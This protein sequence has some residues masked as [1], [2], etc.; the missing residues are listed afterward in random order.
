MI[1]AEHAHTNRLAREKSPYLLQHAHNPVDW[2]PW[3]EEAFAKARK[4]NKPI[5]LSVG[6]STCHWCHVMER[7]SFENEE[8]AA[9]LNEHFVAIK[10]DREERPDVDKVYMTYVLATTGG[11]GWPMS[12]WLT[13][14]LKPFV[15]GT[16]FPPEDRWG[17]P[18]FKSALLQI[19]AA[20]Q[21][22]SAKIVASAATATEQLRQFTTVRGGTNGALE[23][24]LL[25][26]GYQHI[27]ASY[28]PRYGGFG[29]APKFPHPVTLVFLFRYY[30]L[31]GEVEARDMA[32]FTLRKMAEGG[33]H[34]H[35]GGGFH[36][37]A[38]DN[39]WHVPHF[40]KMLYDQA[41]LACVYLEAYQITRDLPAPQSEAARQAGKFYADVARAI[42]EYVLRDMRGAD[43]QF[44]SA[45][46]ADSPLPGKPEEHAEGAFYVWLESEIVA[47]LGQDTASVFNYVYGIEPGGNALSDPQGEFRN[48][49]ILIMR[50]TSEQAAEKF[51]KPPE[52]T[53]ELLAKA[54]ARLFEIRAQRP[55]PHLDDKTITAWN[56][57]MISAFARAAQV[58]DEP[59]Y[60][61]AAT[62]AAAFVETRLFDKTTGTLFRRYRAGEA[63]IS[64]FADDYAFLIQGLLDLYEASFEARHLVWAI[65]LQKKFNELFW[66]NPG[67]GY[68]SVAGGD[69]SVLLRMKASDDGAEPSP[70]A[71]AALNLL[72]LAQMTDDQTFREMADQTL[73]A[74]G[75]RLQQAPSAM[76]Q[77]L[78]ALAFRLG[79]PKQVIIAGKPDAPDTRAMLRE[80]HKEFIPNKTVLLADGGAGQQVLAGYLEFLKTVNMLNGKA[81]AYVCANNVCS[82]PTTDLDT[83]AALLKGTP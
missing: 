55:R 22:D 56:G 35:L 27:K 38:V 4:E 20:W 47:A 6:Y 2:Y 17:R 61:A 79:K 48:K 63:R 45:E 10:V 70:N 14:E 11:G 42:L 34:D 69:T 16:Y 30:A 73:L 77:M 25:K 18:G 76:P 32:L 33:I 68:F 60:L 26:A 72:R 83:M 62:K 66:D 51:G 39:I 43:G 65:G 21:N 8:I 50:Y 58:L 49:N 36:R 52:E 5:F 3:G 37:Y 81:T 71:V 12:V 24:T 31:F 41:Q 57:L 64:G 67:G 1:T 46:D 82:L 19:A 59:R 53:R 23:K 75:E 7:E 44:Y 15:G 54:R 13:P 78:A 40:E 74:F 80:T 28:D 29:G 9:I